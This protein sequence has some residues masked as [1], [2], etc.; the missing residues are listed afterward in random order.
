M[1]A[2]PH[3]VTSSLANKMHKVYQCIHT[4]STLLMSNSEIR[5]LVSD[6]SAL[7]RQVFKDVA[8]SLSGVTEDIG[9]RLQE[10]PQI[11]PSGELAKDLSLLSETNI[12]KNGDVQIR[13]GNEKITEQAPS[14]DEDRG[15]DNSFLGPAEPKGA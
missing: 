14:G 10:Q 15:Q 2:L 7:S 11:E 5:I 1:H 8:F 12:V 9:H 13:E 3:G 4:I 6:I